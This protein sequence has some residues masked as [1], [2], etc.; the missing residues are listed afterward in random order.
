MYVWM[1]CKRFFFCFLLLLLLKIK[2]A[3]THSS[4]RLEM[5]AFAHSK[6]LLMTAVPGPTG[7]IQLL[8]Q[9]VLHSH[10]SGPVRSHG[11]YIYY[12]LGRKKSEIAVL[13]GKSQTTIATWITQFETG[14]GLCRQERMKVYKKH[15]PDRRLWIVRLYRSN[16]VLFLDEAKRLYGIQFPGSTVSTSSIS[17]ILKEAGLS[18]KTLERRAIQISTQEVL[19]FGTELAEFPW[20]LSSIDPTLFGFLTEPV[21]I[22]MPTLYITSGR[23]ESR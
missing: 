22:V 6:A 15:G 20:L 5:T 8:Q 11:L 10:A 9:N 21:S 4:R 12:V 13:F 1:A 3:E 17:L 18:Y 19:R 16:P 23:L 7:Q 2:F 14:G